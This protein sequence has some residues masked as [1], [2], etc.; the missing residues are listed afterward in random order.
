MHFISPNSILGRW[1]AFLLDALLISI[2]WAICSLPVITMGASTA[3]LNKVAMNWMRDRSGCTLGD[4]FRAFK[5]N[6]KTGTGV[7]LILLVP[8]LF[9]LF[10]AYATWIALVQTSQAARWMILIS[11]VLW[12][13]VA[14]YA[15]ALQ[16]IFENPPLRTVMNALRIAVSHLGTTLI[17]VALFALSVFATLLMPLGAFFYAPVCVFLAARPVWGVF[18]KVMAMPEVTLADNE[19]LEEE[20]E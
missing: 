16:A 14:I 8:L 2:A 3:A 10:N 7:W 9:I 18:K 6:W 13:A 5:E 20:G 17:L 1:L 12:L 19:E 11:A 15:F 4:F